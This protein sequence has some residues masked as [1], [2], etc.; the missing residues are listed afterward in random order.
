MNLSQI[1]PRFRRNA[2]LGS[3][4]GEHGV[5]IGQTRFGKTYLAKHIAA[6]FPHV[7]VHAPKNFHLHDDE[8]T[9]ERASQLYNIDPEVDKVVI[10]R[11]REKFMFDDDE[12]EEFCRYI[13]R[14]GHCLAI[15]DEIVSMARGNDYPPSFRFLYTQGAED[16]PHSGPVCVLGLT[17]EPVWV[18]SFV[19]TQSAHHY[20]FYISNDD[21]R[22]KIKGTMPVTEEEIADLQKEQFYYWEHGM[23]EAT[24][25]WHLGKRNDLV[26][27]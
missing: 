1:V 7:I 3:V 6:F 4:D 16:A 27:Q 19:F 14:R 2:E 18:P 12:R 5:I 17:Q 24:G 9:V 11:P 21:H 23:R 26:Q 22:K 20:A 10:Y 25:P 13:F 15:F 8:V